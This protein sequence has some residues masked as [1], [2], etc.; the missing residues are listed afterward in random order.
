M[1][2]ERDWLFADG[3]AVCGVRTVGV[4]INNGNIL[5]QREADGNE[6]AM[7]GGHVRIGETLEDG[8]IRE[9][10]EETGADIKCCRMLWSEECFWEQNGKKAH[11]FAFYHLVKLINGSVI[12]NSGEFVPHR[13]NCNVVFGWLPIERL[14]DIVIYPEFV[15]EEIYDLDRPLRHFVSKC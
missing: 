1:A 13:D 6:Y 4:L 14:R 11:N 12:P 2:Q 8:L 9:F 10:K 15:K 7:P 5:V 3:G